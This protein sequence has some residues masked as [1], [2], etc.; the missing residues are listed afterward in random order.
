MKRKREGKER[1]EKKKKKKKK[2]KKANVKSPTE[3]KIARKRDTYVR[4]NVS[5]IVWGT[6][7][8]GSSTKLSTFQFFYCCGISKP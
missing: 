5:T 6:W 1:I 2:K 3:T 7:W 4:Q 8:C